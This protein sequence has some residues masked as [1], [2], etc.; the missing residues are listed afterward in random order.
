MAKSLLRLLDPRVLAVDAQPTRMALA[1]FAGRLKIHAAMENQALYPRLLASDDPV[2]AGKARELYES[3]G[4]L[5][6]EL[7]AFMKRWSTGRA[8]EGAPEEFSREMMRILQTL[9][10]RM[11]REDTELY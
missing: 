6:E 9:G 1:A 3:S 11:R 7:L 10:A 8:I 5:Y 2:V 4:K